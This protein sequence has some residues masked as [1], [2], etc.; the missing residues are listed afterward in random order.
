MILE[1]S[2]RSKQLIILVFKETFCMNSNI[3]L[4]IVCVLTMATYFL[5]HVIFSMF[6]SNIGKCNV[7][8]SDKGKM[9]VSVSPSPAPVRT[10]ATL[11]TPALVTGV[12]VISTRPPSSPPQPIPNKSAHQLYPRVPGRTRF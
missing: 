4:I 3:S 10:S 9:W 2:E 1:D 5:F 7:H 12:K 11:P 8:V 6:Q